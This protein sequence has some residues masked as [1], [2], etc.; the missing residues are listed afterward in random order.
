MRVSGES[1]ERS[2]QGNATPTAL[3]RRTTVTEARADEADEADETLS[4]LRRRVTA[5]ERTLGQVH[6]FSG[7]H[8]D[9][10]GTGGGR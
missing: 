10:T 1:A 9:G 6:R 3:V 7:E 5:P 2:Q 8:R 4:E